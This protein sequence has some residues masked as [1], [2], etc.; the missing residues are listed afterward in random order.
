MLRRAIFQ[1][2]ETQRVSLSGIR[3]R[4]A[5][6]DR[7]VSTLA[8]SDLADLVSESSKAPNDTTIPSPWKSSEFSRD[9]VLFPNELLEVH[10]RDPVPLKNAERLSQLWATSNSHGVSWDELDDAFLSFHREYLEAE[11]RWVEKYGQLWEEEFR[12]SEEALRKTLSGTEAEVALTM[13]RRRGKVRRMTYTRLA[14]LR[15]KQIIQPF[16]LSRFSE[17]MTQYVAQRVV[18]REQ[19]E[20]NLD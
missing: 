11:N 10:R 20:K 5:C 17:Y 16:S 2:C 7:A 14:R 4:L 19:S 8:D 9:S 12:K 15:N 18:K 1:Y 3:T 13:N 6:E